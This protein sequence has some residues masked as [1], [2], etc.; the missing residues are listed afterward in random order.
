MA[1]T[2]AA[3]RTDAAIATGPEL[4]GTVL[5]RLG[6]TGPG[7]SLE[8]LP[9]T[10]GVSSDIWRVDLP[11]R[12]LCV[13][14]ALPRLKVA[15]DWRV[16]VE[17][18]RFEAAWM[19]IAASVDRGGVPEL[20]GFDE[21]TGTI[22]MEYLPPLEYPV[23]KERLRDGHCDAQFAA[24]V[25]AR[26]VAIHSATADDATVAAA[27]QT[28]GLF[29]ALRLEPYLVETARRHPPLAEALLAI[30]KRTAGTRRALVH[31]DVSPKNILVGPHGP[32]L[33]DA[34]CAWFGD[35]AFDLAFCLNHL[36][37]KCLWNPRVRARL[38]DCHRALASTYLAG[39]DWEPAAALEARAAAL[40][41]ALM[42][43]RIDGKSP[44]EYLTDERD[45]ERVRRFAAARVDAGADA[46]EAI[47]AGWQ[48]EL[49]T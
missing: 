26:L 25:A 34:E 31:G 6:L 29:H 2:M 16:P 48:Q 1:R 44:V 8:C 9:L 10:G 49:R 19:R 24:S 14:R 41:P 47:A 39:V 35:P 5:A 15:A 40:L 28:D 20:L 30:V 13:K 38:L 42:L 23:W 4:I 46:I 18:S 3:D 37:L 11:H 36:L 22:V 27:F 32:V 17:R 33:L 21:P 45:R 7:E 12:T 43:A